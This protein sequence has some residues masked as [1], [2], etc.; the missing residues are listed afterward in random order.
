MFDSQMFGSQTFYSW[1]VWKTDI[2]FPD[3]W[4][5][6]IWFPDVWYLNVLKNGC[7]IPERFEKRIFDCCLF[8][9]WT[10]HSRT[11]DSRTF[12]SQTFDSWIFCKIA[13]FRIFSRCQSISGPKYTFYYDETQ[14]SAPAYFGP[15]RQKSHFLTFCIILVLI[16]RLLTSN[17]IFF[18]KTGYLTVHGTFNLFA[19]W[20]NSEWE[21]SVGDTYIC[22]MVMQWNLC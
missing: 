18:T 13:K 19:R 12:D 4:L 22:Q 16:H 17:A 1:M 3:I 9:S 20:W 5:P 21:L 10:C 11:F 6:N 15:L 8:D 2:W 14:T 7:L